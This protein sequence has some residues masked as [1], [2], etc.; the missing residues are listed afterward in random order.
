MNNT[1]TN[2]ENSHVGIP[3]HGERRRAFNKLNEA[4]YLQE[5]KF[6][7][8]SKCFCGESDF[9]Q[10][11]RFDRF[12]L[13]FGTQICRSC[14]LITQSIRLEEDSLP[15][16]YDK[17]YWP[18]ISGKKTNYQTNPESKKYI[19]FILANIEFSKKDLKVFEV[20]CGAGHKLSLLSETLNNKNYEVSSFGCD[21]SDEALLQANK[22]NIRT[23][24]GGM[25]ELKRFGKSDILILSHVFE[26]FSDL[27]KAMEDITSIVSEESFIYIEVP[28]VND[29]K[30][31][32]EYSFDYQLYNVLAHTYNFSLKSLENVLS[33]GGFKLING[34]EYIR[35][36]FQLTNKTRPY[37]KDS[38]IYIESLKN[39]E[40]AKLKMKKLNKLK[41]NYF[42]KYLKNLIKSLLGR[43]E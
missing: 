13:P 1:K 9:E 34:N 31:K 8:V 38:K 18:L 21:F 23:I 7:K 39:L 11:S 41:E 12:G 24:K 43:S 26:H 42:Y 27:R 25:E 28:G 29:L 37:L 32:K 22:L 15:Y 33:E 3:L 35:S 6:K 10:L 2:L 14:G 5:I 20:G 30:N 36:I 19:E 17:I 4:I 16:F 40:E